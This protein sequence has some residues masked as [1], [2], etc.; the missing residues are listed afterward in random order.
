M[1][2]DKH[3]YIT[4]SELIDKYKKD[5]N[6]YDKNKLQDLRENISLTLFYLADSFSL[7]ISNYDS[8]DWNRKRNYAELIE[9][10]EYDEDGNKNTVAVKES[11]ARIGNKEYEEKVV[12]ALR[13][14]E[15]ARMILS[16]TNQVLNS[17]SS[18]LHMI[19]QS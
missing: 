16:A 2:K 19:Q 12:E 17:I 1:D 13:Q 15:K 14:K 11:L 7:A 4:L 18:R 10:N 9:Q 3:P 8:A 5:K 6:S